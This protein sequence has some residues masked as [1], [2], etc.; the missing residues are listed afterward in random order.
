MECVIRKQKK[1][2]CKDVVHVVT[3]CWNETYKGIVPNEFLAGL[4]D[5]EDERL[6]RAYKRLEESDHQYVLEV[7]HEIAGFINVGESIDDDYSGI[8]EIYA[9]YILK[10]YHG[11]GLGRK[12]LEKGIE[13]LKKMGYKEMIICCLEGNPTNEFYKHMGGVFVKQREYKKFKLPENVYYYEVI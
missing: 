2:D 6:A 10:K 13:E 1:E 12:L 3:L 5:N 11:M 7:D 9:I 4:Y 8:G